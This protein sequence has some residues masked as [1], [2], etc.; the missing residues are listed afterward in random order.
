MDQTIEQILGSAAAVDRW[1][2]CEPDVRIRDAEEESGVVRKEVKK[3]MPKR[4]WVRCFNCN[5]V[6]HMSFECLLFCR[7]DLGSE[8]T[9]PGIVRVSDIVLD[10]G[11]SC[12]MVKKEL[13]DGEKNL[14]GRAMTVHCAHGDTVLYPLA[15]MELKVDRVSCRWRQ[16]CVT[17]LQCPTPDLHARDATSSSSF[18]SLAPS[19][20]PLWN[21][22]SA[23]LLPGTSSIG[24]SSS[25]PPACSAPPWIA[26]PS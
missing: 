13:V 21:R 9:R 15:Q 25:P 12:T 5:K 10:T 17:I 16:R 24:D 26:H 2:I 18:E 11:C 6:G 3:E 8:V 23:K 1:G 14:E 20:L 4:S 19:L 22:S 7:G